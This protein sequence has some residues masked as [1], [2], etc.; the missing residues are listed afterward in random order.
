MNRPMLDDAV[1]DA[2]I[3][4]PLHL[5]RCVQIEILGQVY[6]AGMDRD[7]CRYSDLLSASGIINRCIEQIAREGVAL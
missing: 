5:L 6:Q 4:L 3:H 7:G 1:T 2:N